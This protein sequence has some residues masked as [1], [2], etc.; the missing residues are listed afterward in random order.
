VFFLGEVMVT[1]QV[2]N[3]HVCLRNLKVNWIVHRRQLLDHIAK[4]FGTLPIFTDRSLNIHLILLLHAHVC[5]PRGL[6]PGAV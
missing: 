5:L 2:K 3:F 4:Q 6:F 1:L